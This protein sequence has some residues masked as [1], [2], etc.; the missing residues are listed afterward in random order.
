MFRPYPNQKFI[1]ERLLEIEDELQYYN[2]KVAEEYKKELKKTYEDLLELNKYCD[3]LEKQKESFFK[4]F[5]RKL[6]KTKTL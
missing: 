2:S 3:F 5:F 4:S 6:F 1:R